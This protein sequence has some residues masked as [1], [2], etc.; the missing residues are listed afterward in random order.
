MG[1]SLPDTGVDP[2]AVTA[3]LP[4]PLPPPAGRRPSVV[5][6]VL[7]A[8]VVVGLFAT[9]LAWHVSGGRWQIISTPSMGTA[10]PVGSVVLTRPVVDPAV[11]DILTFRPPAPERD[12]LVTHRVVAV[13]PG[14]GGTGVKTRGDINGA[15]DPWVLHTPDLT[16]RVV[17]VL[18]GVGWLVRALPALIA[19]IV[20]LWWATRRWLPWFWAVPTRVLG[21][22]ILL[23]AVSLWLRPFVGTT[24]LGT[25]ADGG[26][27]HI[28]LVSTGLLPTRVTADTAGSSSW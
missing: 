21:L 4:L 12:R 1:T 17:A 8:V 6:G 13:E 25:S 10:A 18:P 9:V 24:T 23:A 5:P 27:A 16:G 2:D 7:A 20:L 26:G 3:P 22:S 28:A 15:V 14:P 19:G 11:G